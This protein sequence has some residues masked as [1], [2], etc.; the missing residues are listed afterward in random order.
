MSTIAEQLTKALA[1]RYVIERELG[2]GGMA[3]V[4]LAHDI[5]HDRKVAIKVLRPELAQVLGADRF[6]QEIRTI[7]HLQHPNILPLFDSGVIPGQSA[8][9]HG[10]ATIPYYVMPFIEGE[11]LHAR[12]VREGKL[13][14]DQ[15]MRIFREVADALSYAHRHGIVH[16]D[17]KP[18]NIL[19]SESH[20]IVADFGVAKAVSASVT[21][22]GGL[23]T[24]GMVIGTPAYMAPEQAAG[25][26]TLDHRAD[27]YALGALGYEMLT[28]EEMFPGRTPQAVIAA[29]ITEA[30]APLARRVP[31]A[32]PAFA[33]L[34]MRCL[35]KD[36]AKR[37]QHAAEIIA[38]LDAISPV[39]ASRPRWMLWALAAAVMV[40]LIAGL[41]FA[42]II[43][44]RSLLAQ[45]VLAE[46]DPILVADV[47]NRTRDSLLGLT[48]TEALRVDLTQ[49]R[50][51]A[52]VSPA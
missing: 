39:R 29:H 32:S 24:V 18:D 9:G 19:L 52:L 45:G 27:I 42:G 11:S 36:P 34:V 20:A 12:I 8:S 41:F 1:D 46:R 44:G 28:G 30:P 5:K 3:T 2:A 47:T 26:P 51:V 37:P 35:E 50:A 13:P 38:P 48:V 6:I 16:R 7:A 23:T 17:I 4:Y 40:L 33:A 49:S 14:A 15:A 31:T 25:D 21:G 22:G 10:S 43:G